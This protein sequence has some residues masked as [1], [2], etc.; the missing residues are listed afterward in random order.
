MTREGRYLA[1]TP[2]LLI[3]ADGVGTDAFGKS[4]FAKDVNLEELNSFAGQP[5]ALPELSRNICVVQRKT[6]SSDT[7]FPYRNGIIHGRDFGYGNRLVN[8]KCWSLLGN[9]DSLV[10]TRFEEVPAI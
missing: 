7:G 3:I 1:A 10:K 6:S 4:I 2:L 9:V 5:D 8:A